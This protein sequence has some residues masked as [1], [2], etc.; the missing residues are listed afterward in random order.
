MIDRLFNFITVLNLKSFFFGMLIGFLFC[1]V[2]SLG[3]KRQIDRKHDGVVEQLNGQI[4][5]VKL[6]KE[7]ESLHWKMVLRTLQEQQRE[8]RAL[9]I[10]IC[11][12]ESE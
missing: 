4:V 1:I 6:A 3:E 11:G 5:R 7:A 9:W 8:E 2:S 12:K 10:T